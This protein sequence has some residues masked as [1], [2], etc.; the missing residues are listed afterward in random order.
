MKISDTLFADADDQDVRVKRTLANLKQ[1]VLA[2]AAE[3]DIGKASVAEIARRAG[4]SRS[5]FYQ[6]AQSPVDLLTRILCVELDT[7]RI[8]KLREI[9][10]NPDRF[11]DVRRAGMS[12]VIEHVLRYERV[13]KNGQASSRLALR[14]V[15]EHIEQSTLWLI[16]MGV[17]N[18][19]FE[20]EA[21]IPIYA[22][23]RGHGVAAAIEAWL[24]TPA[25]RN[26]DLLLDTIEIDFAI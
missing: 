4:I 1:S 22:A 11:H 18:L 8:N 3:H 16:R 9:E 12:E 23:F 24:R 17:L 5:T 25:P 10:K 20:N 21:I 13:Y 2:F 15:A 6:Y 19:Q 7:A 14:I 26:V